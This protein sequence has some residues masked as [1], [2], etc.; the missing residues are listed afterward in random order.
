VLK[1]FT[2]TDGS[3]PSARLTLSGSV[4][5]GTTTEDGSSA[6]GYG[7]VFKIKTDRTDFMVL[8]NFTGSDGKWSVCGGNTLAH[9]HISTHECDVSA[10]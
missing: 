10:S 8:K 3:G 4:L 7:T 9:G 1:N 5:Y 6:F 2:G